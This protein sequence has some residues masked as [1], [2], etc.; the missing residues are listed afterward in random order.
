MITAVL[1]SFMIMIKFVGLRAKMLLDLE[2]KKRYKEG[3]GHQEQFCSDLSIIRGLHA[4]L[5]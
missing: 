5:E 4:V 2:G 3:K 1:S